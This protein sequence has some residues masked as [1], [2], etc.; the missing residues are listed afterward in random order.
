MGFFDSYRAR[1]R[2]VGHANALYLAAVDQSRQP[3]FFTDY[4]VPDTVDGRFDMIIVHVML[5]IRR[6]RGAGDEAAS[7]SQDILNLMFDDMDRNF[8]EMG[9]SDLSIGKHVKK[10]AKAFYGRAEMIEAGLDSDIDSLASTLLE[11]VY[12]SNEQVESL[13]SELAS[14]LSRTDT[15]LKQQSI[16]SLV[17]GEITFTVPGPVTT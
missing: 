2:Q 11:T 4:K 12:R 3:I 7:L 9:I 16:D 17:Q 1:K 6:F 13:S 15:Q 5:L 8:R 14:Y 10:T